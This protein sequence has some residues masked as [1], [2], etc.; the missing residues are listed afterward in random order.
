MYTILKKIVVPENQSIYQ[1]H[2]LAPEM[3][4]GC[5]VISNYDTPSRPI[6]LISAFPTE[7]E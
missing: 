3:E 7:S 6:S 4:R 2:T 1:F 5:I